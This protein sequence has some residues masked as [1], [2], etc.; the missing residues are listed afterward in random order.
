[1]A[2]FMDSDENITAAEG[3]HV[4]PDCGGAR[5]NAVARNV[6]FAGRSICETTALPVDESLA[7]L[8][9]VRLKGREKLIGEDALREI[10]SRLAFLK[11][12]GL[13]YIALD[14]ASPTLSG[15]E[16][17]RIR[18][19]AQLGS[20]LQGVCYVLDEPT[21]GLHS[22]DNKRLIESLVGLRQ[23]GNTVLVV[24]HDEDT[25]RAAEHI[26]DIGPG[27]GS[28]GGELISKEV[29]RTF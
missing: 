20:N 13:G 7:A 19:A 29:S 3:T 18:L 27:A 2:D 23:K 21:I 17:Q 24:E 28:R 1:M 4:C 9:A 11:S 14:R 12:V 10:V 26:V 8:K 25:I 22:R 5:L 16:A 15:G 6:L